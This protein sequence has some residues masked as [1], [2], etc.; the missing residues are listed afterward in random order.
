MA[1]EHKRPQSTCVMPG[2]FLSF[3]YTRF[4]QLME[5]LLSL[6]YCAMEEQFV[7]SYRQ[8]LE[9]Q[10]MKRTVPSLEK[11]EKGM[12]FITSEGRC[13]LFFFFTSAALSCEKDV[14]VFVL[15][16][17]TKKDIKCLRGSER[18]RLWKCQH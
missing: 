2:W 17:R 14:T 8:R 6:P 16:L 10:S 11:D 7:L 18:W 1:S 9:S 3:Q 15:T 4:L 12:A 5:R 13:R